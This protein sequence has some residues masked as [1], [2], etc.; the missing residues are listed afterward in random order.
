[1]KLRLFLASAL[2]S[3]LVSCQCGSS[4]R[5]EAVRCG[6]GL[7][8]A[9]ATGRCVVSVGDAGGGGQGGGDGS[10]TDAGRLLPD[11]GMPAVCP[12]ACGGETPV[13]DP[14]AQKCV[15]CTVNEGCAAPTPF[16]DP[17][18]A[19][20]GACIGCRTFVDC[21]GES[22]DCDQTTHTCY[23]FDAGFNPGGGVIFDDAGITDHCKDVALPAPQCKAEGCPKGFTCANG[24]CVL[25]GSNGPVQVTL[26]FNQPADLDLYLVEPLPNGGKC[27]IYYGNPNTAP[28]PGLPPL[29]MPPFP[30]PCGALGF[31]DRDSNRACTLDNVDVENII[32]KTGVTATSGKYTVR[33]NLWSACNVSV[34]IPYEVEVRANGDRRYYCGQFKPSDANGGNQGAGVVVTEFVIP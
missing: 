19:P 3:M 22:M 24:Q 23:Q 7:V 2:V 6:E 32:Y 4:N 5:C 15:A 12:V 33:V 1:M 8:C 11:G 21:Q 27:E 10:S 26:R 18:I 9:P 16:C 30:K 28:I 13:C 25:N 14:V 34:T 20:N 31:L 17:T 29:P